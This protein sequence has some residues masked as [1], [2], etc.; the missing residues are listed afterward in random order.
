MIHIDDRKTD[1]SWGAIIGLIVGDAV[2]TTVE[3]YE[4]GS[5]PRVTDMMGGGSFDLKKGQYTDDSIMALLTMESFIRKEGRFDGE[6]MLQLFLLWLDDG[7]G[8]PT[9]DC[10]DIGNTT[11]EALEY[12]RETRSTTLP[13][14]GEWDQGNG[15][16]M[17]LAPVPVRYRNDLDRVREYSAKASV[18]THNHPVCCQACSILGELLYHLIHGMSKS[19]A[20]G[21]E[22]IDK[23]SDFDPKLASIMDGDFRTEEVQGTGYVVDSLRSALWAFDSTDNYEDCILAAVN[24]GNDADTTAAVAGQIAGAYY[25]LSAIRKDWVEAVHGID[26][27][28]RNIEKL[29]SF[30]Y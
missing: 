27:I 26:L 10:F 20:L 19:E 2:G 25:G 14:A 15:S 16:I 11:R 9:G 5:F 7:Y 13:K 22:W 4:P 6:D 8:S 18:L 12:Y 29:M 28:R 3:F 1:R 17:R 23:N 21:F 30:Q 24:L